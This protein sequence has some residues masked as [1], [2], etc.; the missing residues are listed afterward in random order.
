MGSRKKR[1]CPKFFNSDR[2]LPFTNK[3]TVALLAI[4]IYNCSLDPC[5]IPFANFFP[6]ITLIFGRKYINNY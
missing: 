6:K 5:C 2:R 4:E 3:N 1:A